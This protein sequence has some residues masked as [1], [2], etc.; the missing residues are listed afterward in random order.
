MNERR[1]PDDIIRSWVRSG[2]ES[3]SP[4]LFER[5]LKP[6]PR[7]HQRRSWRIGLGGVLGPVARPV[8]AVGGAVA[9]VAVSVAL[10]GRL[11]LGTT[12]S[13]AAA[14]LP[15]SARPTFQL[16]IGGGAG[17]G[18]Y[19]SD[20][21]GESLSLLARRGWLM[22]VPV[23]GREPRRRPR[24]ARR[25][26]RRN[27]GRILTRRG[28]GQRGGRLL[29]VRS[30]EPAGRRRQG[31]EHGVRDGRERC[32]HDDVHD[33]ATTPDGGVDATD[34]IDVHLTVTCPR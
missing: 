11:M 12:D 24:H 2:P 28:R 8:V 17:K 25:L 15:R 9:V 6:I 29:Q 21:T 7:M 33:R 23:R 19:V 16:E 4:D 5:T 20:P 30:G 22:A 13:G 27:T 34:P 18:T 14:E 10:V 1:T 26:R 31:P 32:R 3:A